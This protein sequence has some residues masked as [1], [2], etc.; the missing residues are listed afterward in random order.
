MIT[1][2]EC[3]NTV[4][5]D[6]TTIESASRVPKKLQSSKNV[7]QYDAILGFHMPPAAV[8]TGG[9][10]SMFGTGT[11]AGLSSAVIKHVKQLVQ[12]KKYVDMSIPRRQHYWKSLERCHIYARLQRKQR[13]RN[14]NIELIQN[15]TRLK[16]RKDYDDYIK[17]AADEER[18]KA[19][20]QEGEL[21][22]KADITRSG[23]GGAVVPDLESEWLNA[24]TSK[25]IS[26]NVVTPSPTG[27]KSAPTTTHSSA[28]WNRMSKTGSDGSVSPMSSF[29]LDMSY[30]DH[31][32]HRSN[33]TTMNIVTPP[34]PFGSSSSCFGTTAD[35]LV[36]G[37][38]LQ[39]AITNPTL[40]PYYTYHYNHILHKH[41]PPD[42]AATGHGLAGDSASRIV[43]NSSNTFTVDLSKDKLGGHELPLSSVYGR[44]CAQE[45]YM[46]NKF[47]GAKLLA[48]DMV[49][50][51]EAF[52][53]TLKA[54]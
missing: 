39:P 22:A 42:K 47:I 51:T 50:E 23:L 18:A 37:S 21:H 49:K 27:C 26:Y 3:L 1:L 36:D 29:T 20:A 45:V 12:F 13:E 17:K 9:A 7:L 28:D 53:K 10:A 30:A 41:P 43:T 34:K 32:I 14:D 5:C 2:E 15:A 40:P 19:L 25:K 48:R 46:Q 6:Y 11:P 52:I 38:M 44:Q 4:P 33:E 8:I 54:I 24:K 35:S 16:Q 31:V